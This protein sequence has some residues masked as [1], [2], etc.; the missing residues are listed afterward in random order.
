M[1]AIAHPRPRRWGRESFPVSDDT[2]LPTR[3]PGPVAFGPFQLDAAEARL[4]RDGEPL[5]LTGRPLAVLALLAA[6]P[7]RLL[8]KDAVLDAVW[9]HRHVTESVLKGAVNLLRLTLGD[10]AKAP[11]FVETVPR[12]GYRF[13]AEVRPVAPAAPAA[14][15]APAAPAASN[16]PHAAEPPVGRDAEQALLAQ[17]L[18]RHRLVTL[19]GLGGVGKTCLALAAAAAQGGPAWLLRLDELADPALVLP[20]LAQQLQLGREAAAS[21]AALAA[22]LAGDERLLVLDNAEHLIDA[23]AALCRAL[24]DGAPGVRLLVTSQL[25]L[26]LAPEA[27][28]PL[29]PLALP[30]D[31]GDHAPAPEGYAAAQLLVRR[32]RQHQPQWQPAAAEHADLAAIC[33]ALDGVPL[34]LELAAARVP[35]L[36]LAG[37]RARL[38]QRFALLTRG[39]RDAH[40]RH[41]T[42]AAALDWTFGLL[43]PAERRALQQ[44]A[45]FAGHFSAEDAEGVLGDDALEVLEELRARSLV[46]AEAGPERLRLRL[47]DSVRRH[48]LDS[49]A[50]EGHDT[51]LRLRMLRWMAQR[52]APLP[53]ADVFEPQEQ[54]LPSLRADADSLRAALHFGLDAQAPAAARE[55]AIAL[56]ADCLPLWVRGGLQAE[57]WRW[58]QA[59]RRAADAGAVDPAL[60][61][62]LDVSCAEFCADSQQGDPREMLALLQQRPGPAADALT[63]FRA[64]SAEMHLRVRVGFDTPQQAQALIARLQ[65]LVQPD[66][67]PLAHAPPLRAQVTWLRASGQHEAYLE[68]TQRM[69]AL[70]RR[71]GALARSRGPFFQML[72]ALGLLGRWDEARAG[73]RELVA[74]IRAA[75]AARDQ[76]FSLATAAAVFLRCGDAAA[77]RDTVLLSLRILAGSGMLWWVADALP[78]AAWH[79]GRPADAERLQAR[80]DALADARQERRGPFFG[81]FRRDLL[82]LLGR[83]QPATAPPLDDAQALELALGPGS[84]AA[85]LPPTTPLRAAA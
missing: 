19:T 67:P 55:P 4:A 63:E 53:A 35:L 57:G 2:L 14:A 41:R 17:L 81:S 65:A 46:V 23:V 68:G 3:P 70:Y 10:D 50:A 49:A 75:G 24:L 38:D 16:L 48:A 76:P 61:D 32:I 54:W 37:V 5:A 22:A 13:I 43:S 29:A 28:L 82:A 44:V 31:L 85:V 18:A 39:P 27:V 25:P 6:N 64:A 80:A 51:D 21:P 72:Q 66:W 45:V 84:A 83:E 58:M 59:A 33:R 40:Q 52:L 73:A 9:G 56:A 36:G 74:E 79:D 71:H 47:F 77:E 11:L 20:T 69:L 78:W 12:R 62:R 42:L 60:R 1:A 34:A 30:A 15:P 8:T 7:G 26:R